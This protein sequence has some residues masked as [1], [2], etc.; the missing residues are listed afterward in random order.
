MR[1]FYERFATQQIID[2]KFISTVFLFAALLTLGFSATA[3][4]PI[5]RRQYHIVKLP[6]IGGTSSF[7]TS[8]NNRGWVTGISNDEGDTTQQ[9]VIWQNQTAIPLGTLGGPNSGIIFPVK[10][11][12]GIVSGIAE[13]NMAN[14]LGEEWSCSFFFPTTTLKVCRGFRWENGLMTELKPFA[15]GYNGFASAANNQGQVVGWAENGVRDPSCVGSQVLQFRAAIWEPGTDLPTQ[16]PPLT[17]DSTSAATAMNDRGQVVGISGICGFAVGAFSA[18]HMVIWENGVP[19]PI[20][21]LGGVAWNTPMAINEQGVVVGFSNYRASDGARFNEHAFIWTK[22]SGTTEIPPF[23]GD[24][25]SQALGINSRSQ[26]V[27]FSRRP[28]VF[29]AFIWENETL[30]DLNLLVEPGFSD[31]LLF[32]NDI[33]DRGEITGQA[34]DSVTGEFYAF[35]AIPIVKKG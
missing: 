14:P 7:G 32:A 33:N 3:Q 18:A 2:S 12:R 26:V 9:A 15:G 20:P 10:N 29:R 35:L 28:G 1:V 4:I 25:R 5:E 34:R 24:T 19:T 17:G 11:N 21:G 13:T 23:P 16:L 8:I 31:P 30:Q 22:A 6:N 27:G